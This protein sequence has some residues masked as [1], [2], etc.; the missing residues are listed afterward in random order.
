MTGSLAARQLLSQLS[1]YQEERADREAVEQ[2]I[3]TN[4]PAEARKI[5][6]AAILII[7]TE[8]QAETGF[9]RTHPDPSRRVQLLEAG[10]N[11]I[12]AREATAA[13]EATTPR[14]G[15]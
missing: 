15:L 8:F 13:E 6:N 14:V 10:L 5:L 2:I 12:N 3:D 1:L 4:S 7:R 11:E 9:F